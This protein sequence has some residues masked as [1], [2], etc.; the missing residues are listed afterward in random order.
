MTSG[1]R[2]SWTLQQLDRYKELCAEHGS[3]QRGANAFLL[4]YPSWGSCSPTAVVQFWA[5][6]QVE[7]ELQVKLQDLAV[8]NPGFTTPTFE[9]VEVPYQDCLVLSDAQI[10]LHRKDGL[11]AVLGIIKRRK[12]EMVVFNGDTFDLDW[13]SHF[14]GSKTDPDYGFQA[15]ADTLVAM[16]ELGVRKFVMVYGNH[17]DR[18]ARRLDFKLG[19]RALIDLCMGYVPSAFQQSIHDCLT[20][21]E[22]YY[23]ELTNTPDGIPWRCTHQQNYHQARGSVAI[24]LA[25]Q[26]QQHIIAGHQHHLGVNRSITGRY[27]CVDGGTLQDDS[28][29]EYV[30]KRDRLGPK[31]CVG[32]VTLDQGV[33]SIYSLDAT[34]E[35][36]KAQ[37]A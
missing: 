36:W 2:R 18:V 23:V 7:V 25:D 37:L 6:K 29:T 22:R 32:F 20:V 4:E 21:C 9:A 28:I 5:K 31:M 3:Q 16:Y 11:E 13:A 26:K 15:V 17:D 24:K 14:T 35:W 33:P 10:P 1:V 12:Y 19:H 30:Y 27:W 8:P 34:P